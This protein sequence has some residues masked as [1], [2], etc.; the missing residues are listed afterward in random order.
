MGALSLKLF[1]FSPIFTNQRGHRIGSLAP[2]I[3]VL[4]GSLKILANAPGDGRILLYSRHN[5]YTQRSGKA[6]RDHATWYTSPFLLL[7]PPKK[8]A[9][10]IFPHSL[11]LPA[12]D[13]APN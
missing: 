6:L 3:P 8:H 12:P 10:R 2:M 4:E 9:Q 7:S 1:L 5:S 13:L 11:F